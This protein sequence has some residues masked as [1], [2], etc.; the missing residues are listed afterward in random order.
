MNFDAMGLSLS[1]HID[2]KLDEIIDMLEK[3]PIS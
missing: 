3:R 2:D 1:I